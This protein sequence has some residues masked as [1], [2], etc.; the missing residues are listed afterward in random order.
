MYKRT[1]ADWTEWF[2]LIKPDNIEVTDIT[3]KE[4]I[5]LY[6]AKGFDEKAVKEM[7]KQYLSTKT[8]IDG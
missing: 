5:W 6:L 3:E 1:N 2:G 8:N 4:I 7:I